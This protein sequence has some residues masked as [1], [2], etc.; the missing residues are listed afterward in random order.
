MTEYRWNQIER[1]PVPPSMQDPSQTTNLKSRLISQYVS[2]GGNNPASWL[3][4]FVKKDEFFW[5]RDFPTNWRLW[6]R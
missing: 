6:P 1:I 2:Q 5:I 3:Q 4:S